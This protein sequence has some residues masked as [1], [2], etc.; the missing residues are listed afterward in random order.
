MI[1]AHADGRD[2][3]LSFADIARESSQF[4]HYLAA[5]GVTAGDRVAVMLEPSRAFYVAIFGAI[6]LGAIAVPL[7]TLFGPDGIRLRV[8][9]CAP[10]LL[11]TNAEKAPM[12]EGIP[13]TRVVVANARFH[14]RPCARYPA[15]VRAAPRAATTTRSTSTRRARRASCRRRSSTRTARSS[16]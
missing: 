1:L 3:Q 8:Q 12:A 10:K 4:A 13:G 7:F 9:D 2:E 5:Q 15:S 14:A 6:K 16:R 11:I